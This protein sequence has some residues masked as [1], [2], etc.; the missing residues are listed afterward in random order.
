[1]YEGAR[2][3]FWTTAGAL[4]EGEALNP[5][6]GSTGSDPST[7]AAAVVISWRV[8]G[9]WRGGKP[10]TYLSGVTESHLTDG[11][12]FDS[13]YVAAKKTDA[14]AYLT[15]VRGMVH[16]ALTVN[17]LTCLR[18]FAN[19]G[20]ESTPRV[21]LNPPQHVEIVGALARSVVGTQRRRLHRL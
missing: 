13:A 14:T 16:G 18:R 17:F 19:G 7:L 3:K 5:V 1:V 21:Y 9:I 15:A 2:S 6:I 12:S 11:R 20:S 10:R 4:F 8:R